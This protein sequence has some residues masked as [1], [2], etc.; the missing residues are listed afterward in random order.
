MSAF[1]YTLEAVLSFGTLIILYF[2]I[3]RIKYSFRSIFLLIF[4]RL[5]LAMLLATLKLFPAGDFFFYFDT[6]L[7]GILLALV[8]LGP[9]PP[10]LLIFYGLFAFTLEN[11][12]YRML[13]YFVLPLF[14][15]TPGITEDTPTIIFFTL[16][17][18]LA[19]LGFLKWL[20]Y[21]FARLRTENLGSKDM[22]MLYLANW[23]MVLYHL[24]METLTYL[25]YDMG[26]P[27]MPYRQ[28]ILV[29]YLILFMGIIKQLDGQLRQKLQAQLQF[30]QDM[31][32][33]NLEQYSQQIEGLYREVRGFRHDYANLMTT[34]RL[35][36]E[37]EDL[38][39]IRMV[40]DSVMAT[41]NSRLKHQ[42]YDVG[43]LINLNN[44]ALKSL[45][46]AKFLQA[47]EEGVA[48][49]LE[50]PEP[51][52]PAGMALVDFITIVSILCD[53][54]REAALEAAQP[55]LTIAYLTAKDKQVFIV[56]NSTKAASVAIGDLYAFGVT[57]KGQGRG[58][59]L[60]NAMSLIDR[61]PNVSLNT[62][63]SNHTF[64]QVLEIGLD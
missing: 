6:P 39:Q 1:E 28:F 54:A 5:P 61:Y 40:Y 9:L 45:L 8:L 14:G 23:A 64:C 52:E 12:F 53:N 35:G 34:L 62:S 24:V 15:R 48:V 17:T 18:L 44:S 10:T 27:N 58:I 57:S 31:Q 26:V 59:G 4:L 50:V 19:V 43:R 42:K 55:K 63:S 37:E 2:R 49:T 47:S 3:N 56:E 11:L 32:L 41:A 36:I 22:R 16:S 46:A 30:Q 51:I 20:N 29:A 25:E 13:A 60:Y 21:D 33:T 7:Y 38:D